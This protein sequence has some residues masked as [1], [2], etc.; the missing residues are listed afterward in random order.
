MGGK[1]K[2]KPSKNNSFKK[3]KLMNLKKFSEAIK[4]LPP[5]IQHLPA[6]EIKIV[7]FNKKFILIHQHHHPIQFTEGAWQRIV[8][9][10]WNSTYI[11]K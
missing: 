4:K 9:K 1:K 2:E 11:K 5:E 3:G 10:E 7:E 6:M 8:A